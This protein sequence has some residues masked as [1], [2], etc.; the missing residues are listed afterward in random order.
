MKW[1]ITH[2]YSQIYLAE[3]VLIWICH[4]SV[5]TDLAAQGL[6]YYSSTHFFGPV[7]WIDKIVSV[8]LS[9]ALTL[10]TLIFFIKK[11]ETKE[12]YSIWNHHNCI[13]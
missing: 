13:S 1:V 9:L 7:I 2:Q 3:W 5:Y 4:E 11:M 6:T 12:F 8:T 10:K